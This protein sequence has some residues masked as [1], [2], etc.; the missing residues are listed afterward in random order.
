[1]TFPNLFIEYALDLKVVACCLAIRRGEFVIHDSF[2]IN[3]KQFGATLAMHFLWVGGIL[4]RCK[5]I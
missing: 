1:M 4:L 3:E 2:I 5:P